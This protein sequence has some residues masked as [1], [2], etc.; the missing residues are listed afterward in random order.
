MLLSIFMFY[1]I[2]L[3]NFMLKFYDNNNFMLKFYDNIQIIIKNIVDQIPLGFLLELRMYN[4]RC[5]IA[6]FLV[7]TNETRV[8]HNDNIIVFC[9]GFGV[10]S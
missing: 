6:T 8:I 2:I 9:C 3:F 10:S 1:D 4:I 5:S 7:I